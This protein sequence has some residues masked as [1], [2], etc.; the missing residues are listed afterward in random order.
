MCGLVA[1]VSAGHRLPVQ[2]LVAMTSAIRHRG[3]DDEGYLVDDG[4][5]IRLLCGVDTP[6]SVREAVTESRP[7]AA[8][9]DLG[10]QELRVGLGHRRLSIVDLSPQGHQP[11]RRGALAIVFN[12]EIYDHVERRE[13]LSRL[14]H[15]FSSGSDTEVLLAAYA[16]W[17]PEAF[18]RING[19]WACVI[20]DMARRK[21]I[22]S[23]DR[24]GVKPL[25]WWQGAPGELA[26]ASEVKS[27]LAHPRIAARPDLAACSRWVHAGPQSWRADTLFEGIH[28]FPAAHWAEVSLDAPEALQPRQYWTGPA[29]DGEQLHAP[30][31]AG[32]ADRLAEEYRAL[33]D[34]A[35]RVRMRMDVRFG[36]ALSG[37]LDSSQIAMLVNAEL[38]RR[39]ITEQQEVFSSVYRGEAGAGDA[40]VDA[41]FGAKVRA[42]DE[43]PFIASVAQQL[44][45]RSNVIEP[46]WRDIPVEHERMIWA[47]DVPPVNTLMSSWHTYALVARR[48]VVVTLDG[49]GADEQL[50]G[51]IYYAR[52]L[53]VHASTGSAL[54]QSLALSRH[55]QGIGPMIAQGLA[56]HAM[57]QLL[58]RDGLVA[59][60]RRFRRGQSLSLTL[61]QALREDFS[62]H[63]QTLLFYADKSA[64]A[65]SVES[66]MPFMDWRL[67]NFLCRLPLSYR[68]HDGW[69]KWLARHAQ[70]DALPDEVLWRRDKLGWAI[71]EAAWFGSGGPLN[72]WLSQQVRSS[73]FAQ[74]VAGS[75]GIAAD[76]A[77]PTTKLR[78]L[79]LAVWSRLF[80]EEPGR[81]GRTLG[82]H[83][84]IGVA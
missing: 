22:I 6:T 32:Q 18:S 80:F 68:I 57:R 17:G 11:M 77:D 15:R 12:G 70:R 73:A 9:E 72:H 41:D 19:M 75:L 24:Y 54:R 2:A 29:V 83:R 4:S 65:W 69:T 45:V 79:N 63:L 58:G 10:Q 66:R 27:L 67:V 82:R 7:E 47:L 61:E 48:G 30:F 52:N 56:G 13:E 36:T 1:I 33:L 74:E 76:R 84:E 59:L 35:V 39:G 78:L 23:R 64:M 21:L 14:G 42:A 20:Y 50:A 51:Y 43:S 60:T 5:R 62:T 26:L 71:P 25:Y 38:R 81:P 53:L 31:S 34:D 49:Q 40:G 46:H 8:A 37:G 16:T 44:G 55:V 28:S 3:P